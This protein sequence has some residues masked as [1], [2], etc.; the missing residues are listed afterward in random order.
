MSLY[1]SI[2]VRDHELNRS[3]S[4]PRSSRAML[5]LHARHHSAYVSYHE[6]DPKIT[7]GDFF[8]SKKPSHRR[9]RRIAI[10]LVIVLLVTIRIATRRNTHYLTRFLW[11]TKPKP[12][13]YIP[14]WPKISNI[15]NDEYCLW[16]RLK[17]ESKQ[18]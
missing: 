5:P 12:F 7:F 8:T 1:S 2:R 17:I 18:S 13:N 16:H 9:R 6:N 15:T 14:L 4:E 3:L 11:D 10:V